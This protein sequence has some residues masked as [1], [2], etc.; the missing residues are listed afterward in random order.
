MNIRVIY[1]H[2]EDDIISICDRLSW[3]K[4]Q[5]ALLVLPPE[6]NVL[7]HG[8]DLARLRRHADRLRL[9]IALVCANT[10]VQRQATALGIPAFSTIQRATRHRRSW[11]ARRRE[12]V[13]L[14][15]IGGSAI[16]L[17]RPDPV[18]STG[19]AQLQVR[20]VRPL[21]WWRWLLRYVAIFLFFCVLALAWVAF[22]YT[23]PR[24]TLRL[25]PTLQPLQVTATLLADPYLSAVDF[26]QATL[27]ARLL[28]VENSWQAA[29][30]PTGMLALPNAPARGR[31]LFTNLQGVPAR[32]P[33][34]TRLS[35][36][37][38]EGA[39]FRT[40][41]DVTLTDVVGST[42]EVEVV[43]LA[44]GP[45]GNVAAGAIDTLEGALG[46]RVSVR[47]PEPLSGGAVQEIT[48]VSEADQAR[49]RAQ[50][51]QSLQALALA[52]MEAQV[53]PQEFLAR[54]SLRVLQIVQESY[55]H[56]PGEATEKLT[57]EMRA[58]LQ[59]TAVNQAA[60]LGIMTA[61]LTADSPA[62]YLLV[63]ESVSAQVGDV[64]GVDEA[65]RVRFTMTAE[66]DVAAALGLDEVLTA[67]AGQPPDI[68]LSYLY[69]ELPLRELPSL[70]IWPTWF[71][72]V[73]YLPT[74]IQVEISTR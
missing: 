51:L 5:R 38:I 48:A 22:V 56:A 2:G 32:I 55:S 66:G 26:A 18:D 11:R 62:G 50:V 30:V 74:R 29:L 19:L 52:Q 70:R 15:T 36:S 13:G 43:A 53:T 59:A 69:Q 27:P 8:L 33:A 35:A 41:A 12:R 1:L 54:P 3:E 16:D 64:L 31:V 39:L 17:L 34:G 20:L 21:P 61:A 9:E 6:G 47:N 46:R 67:V 65:G 37:A 60:A 7:R 24:A 40:L 42:A 63:P 68:A 58:V 71:S 10:A 28:T 72:R 4:A 45:Q 14:P 23:V 44:P 73:P 49:L 25:H 57:L